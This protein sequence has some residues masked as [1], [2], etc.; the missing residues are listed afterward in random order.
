MSFSFSL[1]KDPPPPQGST[2]HRVVDAV[3]VAVGY[4]PH[5]QVV[6]LRSHHFGVPFASL[7]MRH[8]QRDSVRY[9][10]I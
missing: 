7:G 6:T 10:P 5:A 9:R 1:Q 4:R 8:P 3:G 2:E